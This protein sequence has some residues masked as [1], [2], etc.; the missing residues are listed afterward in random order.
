MYNIYLLNYC[1][2]SLPSLLVK[3]CRI[4]KSGHLGVKLPKN[5]IFLF[6]ALTKNAEIDLLGCFY[7]C[8]T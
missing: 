2:I 5:I 3:I 8:S 4:E 7:F 1:A 6:E